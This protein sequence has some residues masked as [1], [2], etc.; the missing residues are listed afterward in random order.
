MC[1]PIGKSAELGLG[2]SLK[3]SAWYHAEWPNSSPPRASNKR[4]YNK[5]YADLPFS[6]LAFDFGVGANF[7]RV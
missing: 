3:V 7:C 1:H 5:S 6:E 4:T 2:Y